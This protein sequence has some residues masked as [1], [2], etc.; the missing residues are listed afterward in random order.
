MDNTVHV[1]CL[2]HVYAISVLYCQ[3]ATF[4]LM[5]LKTLTSNIKHHLYDGI[6]MSEM[7]T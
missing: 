4:V 3:M 5:L 2:Q 1:N 6:K 7:Q